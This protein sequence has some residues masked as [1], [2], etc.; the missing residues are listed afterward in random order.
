MSI[1]K[2]LNKSLLLPIFSLVLVAVVMVG[3]ITYHAGNNALEQRIQSLAD[4]SAVLIE[5]LLWQL[6][7]E[8]L[9]VLLDEYVSLGVVSAVHIDAGPYLKI[10]AG[11]VDPEESVYVH[12]RD[13][14]H[15]ESNSVRQTGVL[16]LQVSRENIW[17]KVRSG[18]FQTLFIASLAVMAT[19]FIIQHL[20][21][22]RLITPV[23]EIANGLDKWNGNWSEFKIELQ[24]G[25]RY[26]KH[27]EDELDRL[28][29]AIHGMRDHILNADNIIESKED[30]LLGAA[31]IAGIGYA[32]FDFESGKIIECDENFA[33]IFGQSVEDM[34]QLSIRDDIL[35]T[36]L[37][38]EDFD[39]G[40][41]IRKQLLMGNATEG[42]FRIASDSGE[43]RHIRQLYDVA[44]GREGDSFVVRT[45]AQDVTELNRLQSTLVHAQ[46]VKAIGNLTGG[47]AHDFNNILAVIS[48]NLELLAETITD[49][50]ARRY[51]DTSQHA[52]RLGAELTH[53][54]LAFA[55]KQ[56]LRPEVL[57][58]SRLVRESLSL[59][60]TSV[61]ESVDL[62]VVT[63]GGLWRTE[64]D[65]AQLEAALLNL[66]I[67]AR[68]AMPDG[69]KL[70]IDVSNTRLDRGYAELHD[71]VKAGQ[72]VCIAITD[73]GCGMSAAT[74]NQAL[75][76]FFTTKD[77]GEGTGLGLPMAFG[78]VKQ[79]GG[80]LKIYSE[81]DRGTTVKLYLPR[82]NAQQEVERP[83]FTGL[84]AAQ[85]NGLHVFLVE[86]SEDLRKTFTIQ[87][88]QMGSVVHSAADG[89]SV[90][91]MIENIP[92]IDLILCD[93][94]LP[95][96]MKGPQVVKG[97]QAIYPNAAIIYM[98]GYTENAIIHQG[99]LDEGVIMLQKPFSRKELI[100]AFAS[101]SEAVGQV[102]DS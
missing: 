46:K 94:I 102:A 73:S 26:K 33:S 62:E 48:G 80:H 51:V 60:R 98:S 22:T 68:D 85:F 57:D 17:T 59:L 39:Q 101:A 84:S 42:L 70:T 36:R 86:D 79:S 31:Q 18:M 75:E 74:I 20:L 71:E 96:G 47:V 100:T 38:A 25:K 37:H 10:E 63:D 16:T 41:Q 50:S 90:F 72:Y 58:L 13:L 64:V 24:R 92:R 78:F 61:G 35:R 95:Y 56:P 30:R 53:Q 6:D 32:S 23:L 14:I 66:V 54:L 99:R 29:H 65:K 83:E 67:N 44:P 2:T 19:T 8:T 12:S 27:E 28:V 87:L 69:G 7:H 55:R 5:E 89:N 97:L 1:Q 4:S 40:V 82:V 76:P 93:V 91:K 9:Q 77:V 45:V 81:L 34:L 43:Y 15:E 49:E 3:T 52:V 88:E 11:H 21:T